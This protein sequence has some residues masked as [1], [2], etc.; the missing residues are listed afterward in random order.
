MNI[1]HVITGLH[2]GGAETMLYRLLL[3]GDRRAYQHRV[4]SMTDAGPL[5]EKIR[6]LGVPVRTLGMRQ[7]VPNPLGALRLARLLR[8]DKVDIVQT[9]MYQADLVGALAARIAGRSSII[10]GIHSTRLDPEGETRLK[11]WTVQACAWASWHLPARIICCSEASRKDHAE[12]GYATKKM[13]VIPNGADLVTFRPDPRARRSV[14]E[15]LGVGERTPL[16]G[17]AARFHPVK[18][19]RT[20]VRAAALLRARLPEVRFLLCGDG[21]D[22]DNRKLVGWLN[23]AG[24]RPSC[25]LLGLRA[26]MPRVTA[27]LD[28]ASS[29]SFYGEAWP[30]VMGEAM[31]CG[32]PCVATDLG[33]CRLILGDTGRVVPPKNAVALADAW[34]EVL[35]L[36]PETR[37][38]LGFAARQRVE[39]HFDLIDAVTKYEELYEQLAPRRGSTDSLGRDTRLLA[40]T[41]TLEADA[42]EAP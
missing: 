24:I 32:V 36:G 21:I 33:D 3:Y 30:L 10:W 8:Q 17:L 4:I 18:D 39:E 6:A 41:P 12:L 19:H 42:S 13:M 31:A 14:R 15:E 37:A 28:V 2:P 5:H 16:V 7:G 38:R 11:R 27:A 40:P 34:H 22:W 29:S 26:D 1:T 20:F 25:H 9:W 35:T 23:E